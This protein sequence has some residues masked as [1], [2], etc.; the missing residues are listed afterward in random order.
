MKK[1][2]VA[3]KQAVET[4]D[5]LERFVQMIFRRDRDSVQVIAKVKEL[6][7]IGFTK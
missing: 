2:S 6:L 4:S 5:F 7:T 1:L 3:Q